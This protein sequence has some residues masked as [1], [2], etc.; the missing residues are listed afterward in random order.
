ME[1][2]P[3]GKQILYLPEGSE[4]ILIFHRNILA[5]EPVPHHAAGR[6]RCGNVDQALIFGAAECKADVFLSLDKFP[7]NEDIEQGKHFIRAFAAG[8]AFGKQV[9]F[10][11]VA[12][13]APDR[14]VG[15]LRAHFLEER[16]E[17]PLVIRFERFSAQQGKP[18]D[19]VRGKQ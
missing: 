18:V 15:L 17:R 1:S 10:Q 13:I 11:S 9:G 4:E 7:I 19:I 6:K 16:D 12:G 14:F 5:D 8:A 3:S 2:E